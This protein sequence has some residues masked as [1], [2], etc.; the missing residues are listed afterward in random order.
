MYLAIYDDN[1]LVRCESIRAIAQLG[2]VCDEGVAQAIALLAHDKN[3]AIRKEANDLLVGARLYLIDEN[4][5]E[6]SSSIQLAP[7]IRTSVLVPNNR[8][9]NDDIET[10]MVLE[11][12]DRL[13]RARLLKD[14]AGDFEQKEVRN[15]KQM[16]DRGTNELFKSYPPSSKKGHGKKERRNFSSARGLGLKVCD[17]A[18][19]RS[20]P[21][22]AV[23]I[24][25]VER[26]QVKF[27]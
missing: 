25:I 7:E 3:D 2:L 20:R 23:S 15:S 13:G 27:L 5:V 1:I 21:N 11:A 8:K 14:V 12:V 24:G 26:S 19:S 6:P 9:S 16:L 17:A 22:S 4:E 10:Q 18:L